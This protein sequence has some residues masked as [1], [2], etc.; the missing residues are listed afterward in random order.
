MRKITFTFVFIT[1]FY[2]SFS[3]TVY[4]DVTGVY[5]GTQLDVGGSATLNLGDSIIFNLEVDELVPTSGTD[6]DVDTINTNF[7]IRWANVVD[8][9]ASYEY[10]VIGIGATG[11]ATGVEH[12]TQNLIPIKLVE[13]KVNQVY[14]VLTGGTSATY[15]PGSANYIASSTEVISDINRNL[16]AA[17]G[18]VQINNPVTD[19]QLSILLD[20][21]ISS[22]VLELMT[23]QGE[24]VKSFEVKDQATIDVS[25]LNSGVYLLRDTNT[26]SMRK[27]IIQ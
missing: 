4:I 7:R 25:Y 2:F 3:S 14:V 16:L 19:G 20:E 22:L 18:G 10:G 12:A 8:G 24:I 23:I 21:D 26:M 11:I 5:N 6:S 17:D 15:A 9:P 13:G 1:L 27:I